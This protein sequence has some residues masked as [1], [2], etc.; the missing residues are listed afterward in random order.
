MD[1][2]DEFR[3]QE[4]SQGDRATGGGA[5]GGTMQSGGEARNSGQ[6]ARLVW[7][8]PAGLWGLSLFIF[9]LRFLTLGIYHF[10]GKTEVRRRI[11]SAVRL[12]GQP[13][14]YTGTG[15]EL[16]LGFVIVFPF[17]VV[18]LLVLSALPAYGGGAF[19]AIFYLMGV[20]QYRARNYRLSR[21]NWRGIRGAM[22]GSSW[23]YGL[24]YLWTG[25][26]VPLTLGWI[27]PWR[28]TRLNAILTNETRFGDRPLHFAA[29]VGPLYKYY[30]LLWGGQAILFFT[31]TS[32]LVVLFGQDLADMQTRGTAPAP[33][34]VWGLV[35][36]LF[37]VLVAWSLIGVVYKAAELRYFARHTRFEALRFELDATA[38]SLAR[39]VVGNW[40]RAV[41]TLG[42]AMPVVQARTAGYVLGRLRL[43]GRLDE[44]AI[45]Q[46]QR[47]RARAGEGLAEAFDVDIF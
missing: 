47:A 1:R 13:L 7:V 36:L 4:V 9:L 11:W 34:T 32:A 41:L 29:A 21:T 3:P 37:A 19:L 2:Q 28:N 35:I 18:P 22:A 42:I 46:S 6:P 10:W 44:A 15:W 30:A 27:T 39:L 14:E 25:M 24:T 33:V 16:F 40:L 5:A 45:A 31:A 12:N 20:G 26:L 8:A 17:I 38:P 43:S 23:R